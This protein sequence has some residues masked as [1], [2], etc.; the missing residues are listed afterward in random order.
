MYGRQAKREFR[1]ALIKHGL[2]AKERIY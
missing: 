2:A 1:D